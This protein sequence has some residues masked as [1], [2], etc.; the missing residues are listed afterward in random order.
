MIINSAAGVSIGD[1]GCD[2]RNEGCSIDHALTIRE[3][4][5]AAA[6]NAELRSALALNSD[7]ELDDD[8][9]V[10]PSSL[11]YASA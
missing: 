8:M 7:D 10:V 6:S 3:L 5:E 2:G 4:R 1:I 11:D 9:S